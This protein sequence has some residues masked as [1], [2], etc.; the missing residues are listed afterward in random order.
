MELLFLIYK[1]KF[2]G[3][4]I[5]ISYRV[6]WAQGLGLTLLSLT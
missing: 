3:A 6:M 4:F 2:Q 1:V 5:E